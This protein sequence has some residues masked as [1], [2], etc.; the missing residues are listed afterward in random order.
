MKNIVC[1]ALLLFLGPVSKLSAQEMSSGLNKAIE[2]D[3][4]DSLAKYLNKTKINECHG[5][6]SLLSQTVR[7]NHTKCFQYLIVKG[8]DVNKIC[9]D[10]VPPLMHAVKYGRLE[11]VKALI[12]AGADPNYTYNG[13]MENLKGATPYTYAQKYEQKE[14]LA[15]LNTLKKQ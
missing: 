15:Y 11:M 9:N 6:Y 8:A 7:F 14:I 13:A 2:I 5:F 1:A 3:N 10:Y 4:T 12:K